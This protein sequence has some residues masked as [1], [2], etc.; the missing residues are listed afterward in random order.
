M[1]N[2]SYLLEA[3]PQIPPNLDNS[4]IGDIPMKYWK[5]TAKRFPSQGMCVDATTRQLV[6]MWQNVRNTK[7]AEHD[8]WWTQV[9]NVFTPNPESNERT[10]VSLSVRSVWDLYF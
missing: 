5:Q 3:L 1:Y 10:M 4:T 9:S 2:D 7:A 6:T 8:H